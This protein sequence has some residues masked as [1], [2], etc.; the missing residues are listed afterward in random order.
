[1][2]GGSRVISLIGES[3]S[4][5]SVPVV[6]CVPAS[7]LLIPSSVSPNMSKRTGWSGPGGK[8]S[9]IPPRIANSPWLANRARALVAVAHEKGGKPVEI[10]GLPRCGAEGGFAPDRACRQALQGGGHGG[11]DDRR[12][13]PSRVS[14]RQPR[15]GVDPLRHDLAYRRHPVVGQAVPG[16]QPQHRELGREEGEPFRE[17]GEARIVARDMKYPRPGAARGEA[18]YDPRFERLRHAR[19]QRA[20][21][22]GGGVDFVQESGRRAQRALL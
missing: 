5:F 17:P 1:M 22:T 11:Q 21:R 3:A 15:H 2:E 20:S 8:R 14:R 4:L 7:K 19:E 6:R 16:G 13:F 12:P 9:T 10:D 18:G